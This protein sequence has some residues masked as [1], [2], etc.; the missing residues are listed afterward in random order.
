MASK[1]Q[2][3]RKKLFTISKQL[4]W[5]IR[6]CKTQYIMGLE[7][8]VGRVKKCST[9]KCY[10]LNRWINQYCCIICHYIVVA[11]PLQVRLNFHLLCELN[12]YCL[13]ILYLHLIFVI[14]LRRF[15]SLEP[16]DFW[17][18]S[19]H[20]ELLFKRSYDFVR[21]YVFFLKFLVMGTT[22]KSISSSNEVRHLFVEL[23]GSELGD[24]YL[25]FYLD[26]IFS[27]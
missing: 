23:V 20:I 24:C 21:I 3:K 15:D 11:C 14:W 7:Y 27:L 2:E 5:L 1:G 22:L 16:R 18:I 4:S 6:F 8:E 17:A 13:E 10:P 19:L 12:C 25:L 26:L 9:V